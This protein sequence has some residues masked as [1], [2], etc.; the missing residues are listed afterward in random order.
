MEKN[1]ERRSEPATQGLPDG[2]FPNQRIQI[3]VS[4]GGYRNEKLLLNFMVIRKIFQPFAI[5]T[6]I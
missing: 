5:F 6:D 3:W 2:V 1:W 4:F